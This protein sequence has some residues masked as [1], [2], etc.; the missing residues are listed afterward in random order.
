M[1]T[2]FCSKFLDSFFLPVASS[3]VMLLNKGCYSGTC[4]LHLEI[5]LLVFNSPTKGW[6]RVV[7]TPHGCSKTKSYCLA[8]GGA[9]APWLVRSSPC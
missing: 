5:K 6:L 9:V 2:L 3:S 4:N 1:S 7:S 8:C